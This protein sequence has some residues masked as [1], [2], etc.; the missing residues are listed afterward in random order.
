M[1]ETGLEVGCMYCGED[2]LIDEASGCWVWSKSKSDKGYGLIFSPSKHLAHRDYYERY[3]GEIPTGFIV[4]HEC[5]NKACVNPDHLFLM[6]GSD[7]MKMH[8]T[9]QVRNRHIPEWAM[10]RDWEE[11]LVPDFSRIDFDHSLSCTRLA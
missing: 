11:P 3:R 6:T 1:P 2:Y 8:R 4:H 10:E 7:H 5:R 9:Q